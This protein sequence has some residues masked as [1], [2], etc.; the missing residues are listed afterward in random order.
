MQLASLL[1]LM[2]GGLVWLGVAFFDFMHML[3]LR[4]LLVCLLACLLFGWLMLFACLLVCVI[5]CLL[6][7][8]LMLFACLLGSFLLSFSP[9]VCLSLALSPSPFPITPLL[10]LSLPLSLPPS[11]SPSLSLSLSPPSSLVDDAAAV[12]VDGCIG[13]VGSLLPNALGWLDP[14]PA[15]R[16]SEPSASSS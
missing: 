13:I 4:R 16:A 7:R 6:F 5:A 9:S 2:D 8:W 10:S 14:A 12:A 1:L 3:A 11:L 15:C